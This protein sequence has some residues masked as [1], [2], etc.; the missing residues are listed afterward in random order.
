MKIIHKLITSHLHDYSY[1]EFLEVSMED[2][3]RYQE[4]TWKKELI[5]GLEG[6]FDLTEHEIRNSVTQNTMGIGAIPD[7]LSNRDPNFYHKL[8]EKI[9]YDLYN[10]HEDFKPELL[11]FVEPETGEFVEKS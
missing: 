10:Q 9:Y 3:N 7:N 8:F 4:G 1:S 5:L 11:R 2:L 6:L